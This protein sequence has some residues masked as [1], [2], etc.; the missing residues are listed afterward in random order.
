MS[1]LQEKSTGL[2]QKI[3]PTLNT[4][5]RN[6]Y[7]KAISGGMM[8]TL[9]IN[10]IGSIAVLLMVF[11]I[12]AVQQFLDFLGIKA[13]LG[14][15]NS[16]TMG[17][18]ALY[19]AF[20]LS[21]NLVQQ[22]LPEDDG[23]VPG[24]TALIAFLVVTPLG[25]LEDGTG[26]IPTTWLGAQGVFSAMIIGILVGRSY[27]YMKEKGW[28][29]KMPAGVPPMVTKVFEGLIPTIVTVTCITILARLFELT[30]YGSMHDAIYNIIQR[31]FVNVGGS[32][33][34]MILISIIA[35]IL[36]FFGI[37]GT[38]VTMPFVQAIWMTMDLSNL[39]ATM[40]GEVPPYIIGNAFFMTVT[41]GGTA[42][43]LV[44]NMLMSKSKQYK[45]LGKMAL[46]PAIFGITEPII[47]GTPLVLNFKFAIPF[48]FNNAIV[49]TIA[50]VLT[51]VGIV[52]RFMGVASIFGLPL[53]FSAAIQGSVMI[54]I[55][56]L[57]LHA[58]SI[59]LWRPFFK[60]QEKEALESEMQVA[61]EE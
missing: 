44:I 56:Q 49:L 59:L 10:V 58:L 61:G 14:T 8:A 55:M 37:H 9:P 47:F 48:I 19:V 43:G 21:K 33:P 54:V 60:L 50:Y 51:A 28:T 30:P 6:K 23:G 40:A 27:V 16:V 24:I 25:S 53:G 4:L 39:E 7:L 26:A 18:L 57:A 15:L 2:I 3:V 5:S 35:Q 11:P 1:N 13:L 12:D 32:F 45:Q 29:I 38:N 52:P 17:A 20:F 42:L 34:A 36:W 22:F 31:P 46:V 41:F